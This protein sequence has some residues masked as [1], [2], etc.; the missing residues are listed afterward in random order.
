VNH[1]WPRVWDAVALCGILCGR[2]DAQAV[3]DA[4]V[5]HGTL[6]FDAEAT[7]GAFTGSTT[8]VTGQL[9]GAA[10][11]AGVRGWVEAPSRSLSSQNGKRDRD[12]W[13]SL[14]VERFPT[15]RFQLDSVLPGE[16]RG[17]STAVV[18]LGRFSL[19]GEVRPVRVAG[20]LWNLDNGVRFRGRVPI[21]V[22]EYGIGGLTKAFGVLRMK[23][24]VVVRVDVTFQRP[25]TG[26]PAAP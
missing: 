4:S 3:A 17:D 19:H 5:V 13:A 11:L 9:V 16:A 26:L 25:G 10:T 18:L 21:N 22:K 6:A 7:L 24:Q 8:A 15:L 2:L 1:R 12:T 20:Y 14:E 23:P